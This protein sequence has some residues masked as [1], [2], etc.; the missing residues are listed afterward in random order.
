[1]KPLETVAIV[2]VGLIGGSI[3]LA[4]RERKLAKKVIGVGRRASS[5][6][7]AKR[8]GCVTSTTTSLARGVAKAELVIVCTPIELIADQ[9][10]EIAEVCADECLI[11]DAGSTKGAIVRRLESKWG[12][13]DQRGVT[14]V[15]SHP[16]AGGEKGGPDMAVADL[17]QD[18]P[19]IVTPSH[20]TPKEAQHQVEEFW[21]ALGSQVT[22]MSAEEHDRAVAA[23]SHL[24]HLVA[25]AL[26]GATSVDDLPLTS[27]GFADT[28]RIAA[29]DVDLWRQIFLDNR[30]HILQA[31]AQF[32]RLLASYRKA[33]KADD[34]EALTQ[35][36][37]QA[38][39]HR[40]AVGS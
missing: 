7:K 39:N 16:L 13:G 36:L 25:A 29:G 37:E 1:M 17:F 31:L 9:V 22:V 14:F 5:L 35:L 8:C 30:R 23:I 4:L 3:G 40:D 21:T 26:A 27:T 24:P 15:G 19:A 2:G 34:A 33:L 6:T 28:T 12:G 10:R 20:C 32:E 11:T 38:K 18:R